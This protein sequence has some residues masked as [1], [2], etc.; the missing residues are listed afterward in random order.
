[1]LE[2]D[3]VGYVYGVW[4]VLCGKRLPLRLN[5]AV[6]KSYVMPAIFYHSEVWSLK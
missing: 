5:D 6:C 3:V 2:R 4:R 1:M